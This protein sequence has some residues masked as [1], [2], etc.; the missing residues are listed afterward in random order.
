MRHALRIL[1]LLPVLLLSLICTGAAAVESGS[2]KYLVRAGIGVGSLKLGMSVNDPLL[3][4]LH[5]PTRIM[6]A[7]GGVT[8]WRWLG[9]APVPPH[10]IS[11]KQ[12]LGNYLTIFIQKGKI[13]QIEVSSE[14][15]HTPKG[16]STANSA[17]DFQKLFGHINGAVYERLIMDDPTDSLP[18]S[19]HFVAYEDDKSA[20]IAWKYG[21]WGNMGPEPDPTT[22]VE[23]LIVHI[24]GRAVICDPNDSL[25]YSGTWPLTK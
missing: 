19:K 7:A 5:K 23:S 3:Q 9:S 4:H 13:V 15:F 18:A 25:P 11:D 1:R 10:I 22:G 6:K 8:V 14:S 20:G 21:T 2:T 24:K 12:L 17:Q 16:Y